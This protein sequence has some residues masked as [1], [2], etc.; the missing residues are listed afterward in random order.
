MKIQFRRTE[1]VGIN[2]P[3]TS[4]NAPTDGSPTSERTVNIII[5]Q[6][7]SK[8]MGMHFYWLRNWGNQKTFQFYWGPVRKNLVYYHTKHDQAAHHLAVRDIFLHIK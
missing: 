8:A 3:P 6:R 5:V 2:S 4:G 7:R 1:Y